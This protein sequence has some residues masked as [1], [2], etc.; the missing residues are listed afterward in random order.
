MSESPN[1]SS[2]S[3]NQNSNKYSYGSE[4]SRTESPTDYQ[5]SNPTSYTTPT[6]VENP[7]NLVKDLTQIKALLLECETFILEQGD[8]NEGK[9]FQFRLTKEVIQNELRDFIVRNTEKIMKNPTYQTLLSLFEH[10]YSERLN[11]EIQ[12]SEHI[13]LIHERLKEKTILEKRNSSVLKYW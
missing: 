11:K 7:V 9:L 2:E 6:P 8:M 1:N 10:D 3:S 4:S 13:S 5:Y 12:N